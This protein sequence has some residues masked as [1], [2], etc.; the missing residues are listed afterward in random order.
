MEEKK[1]WNS[2]DLWEDELEIL[3]SIINKTELVETTKWGGIVYTVNNKNVVGIGGFKSFFTIWFFNGVFLKDELNILVNANE[4]V[5]KSLRQWRFS[6]KND[7]NENQILTY[8]KEVIAN[9]KEGKSIKPTKKER[10][11]CPFLDTQLKSDKELSIAFENFTLSKQN[12]FLEYI[13]TA[14]Q[15]KTKITRFEKI[16]PMILQNI[17]LNDKYR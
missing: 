6:S 2:N 14:K 10:I 13:E 7:I 4:G 3:K 1:S 8:I 12:E 15:E 16:K 11:I 17:G 9:E 5:T